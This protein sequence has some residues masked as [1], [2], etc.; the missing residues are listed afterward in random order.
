M[1]KNTV[2]RGYA[3]SMAIG[4]MILT[5]I[6]LSAGAQGM[7]WYVTAGGETPDMAV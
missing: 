5:F 4:T 6:L 2:D 3:F 1:F 7:T